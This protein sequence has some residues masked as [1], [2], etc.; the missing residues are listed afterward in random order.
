MLISIDTK[1]NELFEIIGYRF[2]KVYFNKYTAYFFGRFQTS[3]DL[4]D[5]II[6]SDKEIFLDHNV[7]KLFKKIHGDMTLLIL[8]DDKIKLFSSIYNSTLKVFKEAKKFFITN[9]EFFRN[10]NKISDD[11]GFLKLFSHHGYFIYQ[12]LSEDVFDFILPGSIIQFNK[13]N[14]SDYET[15]WYLNFEEFCSRDDH[16]NIIKELSESFEDENNF[17]HPKFNSVLSLSGGLDSAVLLAGSKKYK[18]ITPYHFA[19]MTEHGLQTSK[20]LCKY[21]NK[22]LLIKHYYTSQYYDLTINTDISEILD[23][24]YKFIEGD[25]VHFFLNNSNMMSKYNFNNHFNINGNSFPTALTI[26][27]MMK[28]P[29]RVKKKMKYNT[30]RDERFYFSLENLRNLMTKNLNFNHELFKDSIHKYY[31]PIFLTL[32]NQDPPNLKKIIYNQK[33]NFSSPI[34]NLNEEHINKLNKLSESIFIKII[35]KLLKSN[36]FKKELKTPNERVAQI[37]LKTLIF[38][39][40]NIR[41]MHQDIHSCDE[42]YVSQSV[43]LNPNI[44]LKLFSVK[45]DQKLVENSKWHIFQVFK[46]LSGE[47]FDKLFFR[48]SYMNPSYILKSIAR[49]IY[50]K[51][52]SIDID[53]RYALI[54]N[55]YFENFLAKNHIVEKYIDYKKSHYF[56]SLMYDFPSKK[57]RENIQL[58]NHNFWKINNIINILRKIY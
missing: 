51:Y 42:D 17:K 36:Y 38:L 25:S 21:L 50:H 15:S 34:N 30:F 55:K 11:L 5:Q 10:K 23:Y 31:N 46:I 37:L 41:S 49:K 19:T 14:V 48:G 7:I 27:H 35:S 40:D 43:G 26:K 53:Q 28:Y 33:S 13:K 1:E 18:N 8:E 56:K 47:E 32:M 24:S 57:E 3:F 4:I 54:N 52:H 58:L 29:N 12:G 22:N 44:L 39:T 2:K 16:E 6:L 20:N 9:K 45:I